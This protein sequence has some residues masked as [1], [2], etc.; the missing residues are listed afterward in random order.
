[1]FTQTFD[2]IVLVFTIQIAGDRTLEKYQD[3]S[4]AY[5]EWLEF[6]IGEVIY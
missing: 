1:M 5:F 4:V 6:G 3:E 2:C